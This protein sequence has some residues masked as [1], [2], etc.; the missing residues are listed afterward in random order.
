MH[1]WASGFHTTAREPKRAHLS[2]HVFSNTTKFHETTLQ[3][4]DKEHEKTQRERENKRT[5]LGAGEGNKSAKFWAVR[6][7]VGRAKVGVGLFR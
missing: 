6:A 1:V 7:Q 5:K 3:M 2:A 4:R